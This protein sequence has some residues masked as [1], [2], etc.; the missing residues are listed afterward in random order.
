M[1]LVVRRCLIAVEEP[2]ESSFLFLFLACFR[3]KNGL[4]PKIDKAVFV[5]GWVKEYEVQVHTVTTKIINIIQ[6]NRSCFLIPNFFQLATFLY[7]STKRQNQ[8][9]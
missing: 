6:I 5:F 2:C 9:L 3:Y 1:D 4:S 8:N 7:S